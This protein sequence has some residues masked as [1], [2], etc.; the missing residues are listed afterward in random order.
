MQHAGIIQPAIGRARRVRRS[1]LVRFMAAAAGR[2]FPA[3]YLLH[4]PPGRADG[5]IQ[6]GA[7][8]VDA[9]VMTARHEIRPMI[10]V[11]P[12]G[13]SGTFGN[14]TEWANARAGPYESFVLDVVHNV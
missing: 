1:G 6:A 3:M 9:D 4:A 11:L 14:D 8:A 2:R 10:F 5:F 7:L 13:K 12:N